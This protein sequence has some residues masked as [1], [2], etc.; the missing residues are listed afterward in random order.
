MKQSWINPHISLRKA[1]PL[2]LGYFA[3]KRIS[4]HDIII[5]QGG[6]IVT[7]ADL[8]PGSLSEPHAWHAFQIER[9]LYICPI[10]SQPQSRD[11]IFLVN[12]SCNPNCG[13]RGQIT[14][15][16]MRDIECNEQILFDY[17]MTDWGAPELG[18]VEM[19]CMCGAVNCRGQVGL[20]DW[21]NKDLQVKYN[22]YFSRY[23]QD[24]I[25]ETR[26]Q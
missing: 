9:E 10:T 11:G 15:V 22:G 14:L 21:E 26:S 6:I 5:V 25:D 3:D 2:D 4:K 1:G 7:E 20:K 24:R 17:A 8:D 19:K 16:A 23:I 18:W 13:L 12:H